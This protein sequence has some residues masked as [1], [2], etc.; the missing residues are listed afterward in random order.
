MVARARIL[1]RSTPVGAL[2]FVNGIEIG[3][4]PVEVTLPETGT[5]TLVVKK[6][7]HRSETRTL[8]PESRDLLV[9][10][11]RLPRGPRGDAPPIVE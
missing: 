11:T 2:A 1:V 7:G 10:L 9:P 3:A 4:T 5:A 6:G 8:T